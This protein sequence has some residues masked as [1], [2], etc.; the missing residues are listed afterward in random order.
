MNVYMVVTNA[1]GLGGKPVTTVEP[2][3][4]LAASGELLAINL[5]LSWTLAYF[6]SYDNIVSNPLKDML[7]YDNV[8]VA[9]DVPPALYTAAPIQVAVSFFGI[10]YCVLDLER[11]A[12]SK[13]SSFHLNVTRA[14]NVLYGMS[15]CAVI[16]IFVVTP[17]VSPQVHS[18]FFFQLIFCRFFVVAA[19]WL[20]DY[21]RVATANIAFLVCYGVAT[22]GFLFCVGAD[23]VFWEEGEL[24]VVPAYITMAFDYT[25]FILLAV[26]TRCL[27]SAPRMV[28]HLSLERTGSAPVDDSDEPSTS[29]IEDSN[30]GGP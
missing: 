27:P 28:F 5:I 14:A 10:R 18:V 1:P 26:T 24:P 11:A 20:E 25:W 4:Y 12:L 9:W 19:N 6:F 17:A 22:F 8:C 15:L 16:M 2:E 7:G 30:A 13:L 21:P 29:G 23:V 3:R